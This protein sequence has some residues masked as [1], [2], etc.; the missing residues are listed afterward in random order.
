MI[1]DRLENLPLYIPV[2]PQ[3][4]DVAAILKSDGFDALP[5]GSHTTDD[6]TLRY[7]IMRYETSSKE[8]E[9]Y[10]VHRR[11]ADVQFI[12]TGRERMDAAAKEGFVTTEAYDEAK[13][14]F[15]GTGQRI[16]SYHADPGHFVIFFP[17]EPH[18]PSLID[19]ESRAVKKVVF[20]VTV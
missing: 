13:D 11:E 1:I 16:A 20:K 2:L 18:A 14:A 8:A 17:G 5:L 9:R 7:N 6:P 19:E 4:R 10:E 15:F 3:L 12:L